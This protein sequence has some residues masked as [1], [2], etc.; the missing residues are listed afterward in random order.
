MAPLS[1]QQAFTQVDGLTLASKKMKPML[2]SVNTEY[3]LNPP[4][5]PL[6]QPVHN[7]PAPSRKH[8]NLPARCLRPCSTLQ[9]C[10]VKPTH[11]LDFQP[12]P[13]WHSH[14]PCTNATRR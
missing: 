5:K 9:R 12:V 14:K 2:K 10:N 1:P 3:G 4:H 13:H 8:P 7:R 11:G 6:S